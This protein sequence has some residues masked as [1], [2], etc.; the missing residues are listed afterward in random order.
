MV[1]SKGTGGAAKE[2]RGRKDKTGDSISKQKQRCENEKLAENCNERERKGK[3][4]MKVDLTRN[5]P[6]A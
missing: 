5:S 3:K 1:E 2:T 4:N 6:S